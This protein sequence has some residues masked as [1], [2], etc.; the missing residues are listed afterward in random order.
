MHMRRLEGLMTGLVLLGCHGADVPPGDPQ[1]ED[2]ADGIEADG[3]ET[4]DVE[5]P[6][7]E[8]DRPP[9]VPWQPAGELTVDDFG[10]AGWISLPFPAG[11]RYVALRTLALDGEPSTPTRACHRVLEA[12]LGGGELL[13]PAPDEARLDHHQRLLPGPGG[14][15]FV[16]STTE[17]PLPDLGPLELR[18]GLVD[19]A[20]GIPASRARFP[21]MPRTL[22]V[23]TAWEPA[24]VEASADAT[25]AVRIARA[26]DSGWGPLADDPGLA[27]AWQVTI[28]RFA[29]VGVELVLESEAI[30]PATGPL[31][32]TADMVAFDD[33]LSS[34]RAQLQGDADDARFVPVALVRCLEFDDPVAGTRNRPVGQATR[35]PGSMADDGTP[36][37]VVLSAGDCGTGAP[38]PPALDPER[39][40]IV[41]AHEIGHYLGLLHSDYDGAHLAGDDGEQ[42]MRSTIAQT[43]DPDTAW[44]SAAQATVLHRH[45]D[46]VVAP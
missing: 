7:E 35:I 36:S 6:I 5:E 28:E 15:V 8:I 31:D 32:Y 2:E 11:Q 45:P 3:V 13:L 37:L 26:E 30:V 40:G 9:P 43:V 21:G 17:A 14:G 46:L 18:L 29:D 38:A 23:D 12:R 41:L 1:D 10:E 24:P 39:Y 27:A 4:D 16:L 20:L 22:R 25:L 44:F 42:L 33:L 34:A 19:C